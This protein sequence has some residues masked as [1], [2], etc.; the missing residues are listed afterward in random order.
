MLGFEEEVG[1]FYEYRR[2]GYSKPSK[3]QVRGD[4]R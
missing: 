2:E 3:E 1:F 4:V